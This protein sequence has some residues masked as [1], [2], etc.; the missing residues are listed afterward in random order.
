M[1][2][3]WESFALLRR[4]LGVVGRANGIHFT[5]FAIDDGSSDPVPALPADDHAGVQVIH[6]VRNLGHQRAIAVGLVEAFRQYEKRPFEALV[7]MDSDGEDPPR[8]IPALLAGLAGAPGGIAVATRRRRHASLAFRIGYGIYKTLYRALCS[9]VL[10][11]GNFCAIS[12]TALEQLV[13][14]SEIWNH[15]AATVSR[16]RCPIVK[17]PHDRAPRYAGQPKMTL[18]PLVLLGM[19]ALSVYIDVIL[20]RMMFA[21]LLFAIATGLVILA[22]LYLYFFTDWPI[23]GW[24]S[25]LAGVLLTILLQVLFAAVGAS[26]LLL[27][28]RSSIARVPLAELPV[29]VRERRVL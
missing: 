24:T 23:R 4:D 17:V 5:V 7:V 12:P 11:Y 10:D 15:L 20:I 25:I 13:H 29:F 1:L 14:A 2:N 6:L 21:T 22:L 9:K 16:Q 18:Q 28:N 3:D 27:S 19:S 8:D 26:F